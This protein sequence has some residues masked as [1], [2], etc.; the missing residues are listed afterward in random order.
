MAIT[1]PALK[2]ALLAKLGVSAQRLSQLVGERKAE[3][4]MTTADAVYT[5][6]H[7]KG[8]DVSRYL[9]KEE[10]AHV[11][12][13]AAQLRAGAP[14]PRPATRPARRRAAAAV[15]SISPRVKDLPGLTRARAVEA[16]EMAEVYPLLY[17]F[18][19]SARD[20]IERVLSTALGPD[21]WEKAV[22]TRLQKDAEN[23][24]SDEAKEPWH[25][26]RGARPIDYV[27]LPDLASIV[28]GGKAWPYFEAIT[29]FPRATW[30]EELVSDM[31]VSR[32][33][34]AHM[35]PLAKDDIRHIEA[36]FRKWQRQLEAR[37]DEIP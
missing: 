29:L 23:R 18:E 33:V 9:D 32:R 19:N 27:D 30:F 20:I 17:V 1:N 10:T 13:L 22:S 28:K 31:N 35:N 6:A 24:K 7:E 26:R 34:V 15:V 14:P 25:G 11:R 37:R 36:T 21:W 4:P 12:V 2:A 5:I 16:K 8:I 3:L